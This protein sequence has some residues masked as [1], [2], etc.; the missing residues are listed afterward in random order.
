MTHY[1]GRVQLVFAAVAALTTFFLVPRG[2]S[3]GN[4]DI[5]GDHMYWN[6][7]EGSYQLNLTTRIA[8]FNPNYLHVRRL[9]H[10]HEQCMQL[11]LSSSNPAT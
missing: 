5:Q 9:P 8:I 4:I 6:I 10:W 1:F 7:S 2:I 3:A 11:M